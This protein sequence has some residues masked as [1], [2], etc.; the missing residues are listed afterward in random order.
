MPSLNN[1]DYIILTETWLTSGIHDAE[2]GMI[3][4]NIYRLD[5]NSNNS[6]HK[7]DV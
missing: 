7:K 5:C 2:L 3:D 6:I 4:Y 1:F